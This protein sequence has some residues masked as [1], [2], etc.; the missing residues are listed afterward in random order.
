MISNSRPKG[1]EAAA[2]ASSTAGESVDT[3]DTGAFDA[4]LAL[5]SVAKR[6][7]RISVRKLAGELEGVE[8]PGA[9]DDSDDSQSD[10][11][12]LPDDALSFLGR[13]PAADAKAGDRR[14]RR[15]TP[16]PPPSRPMVLRLAGGAMAPA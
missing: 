16:R 15:A 3:G 7:S 1:T 11:D 10:D 12:A 9:L 14:S 6:P 4:L 5:Q 13:D 2:N 8:L